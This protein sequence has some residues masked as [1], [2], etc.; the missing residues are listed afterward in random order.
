MQK[1][2]LSAR[3]FFLHIIGKNKRW[4]EI[5][6]EHDRILKF[7]GFLRIPWKKTP[8]GPEK[9]PKNYIFKQFQIFDIF[10]VLKP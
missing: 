3:K 9:T 8:F 5:C 7:A 10:L 1:K 4:G 6:Y 2:L